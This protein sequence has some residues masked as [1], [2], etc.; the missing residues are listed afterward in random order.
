MRKRDVEI[1]T[2]ILQKRNREGLFEQLI[3]KYQVTERTLRNDIHSINDYLRSLDMPPILIRSDGT[4]EFDGTVDEQLILTR[5]SSIDS[6]TYRMQ[7]NER[8]DIIL[9]LLITRRDY[10]TMEELAE[11]LYVSRSSV[12]KDVNRLKSSCEERG[13]KIQSVLG[14]GITVEAEETVCRRELFRIVTD[15]ITLETQ[16][17]GSFQN[18]LLRELQFEISLNQV[19]KLVRRNER[20]RHLHF[21]DEGYVCFTC[22]L[23]VTL[24]RIEKGYF[25]DE[26]ERQSVSSVE[27][28]AVEIFRDAAQEL[29]LPVTPAECV[30]MQ[31]ETQKWELLLENRFN[32]DYLL[33]ENCV[34]EFIHSISRGLQINYFE[35]KVL[36]D[37]VLYLTEEAG[38]RGTEEAGENSML[39]Q[40]M[41][42]YPKEYRVVRESARVLEESQSI[43][44]SE[45]DLANLIMHVTAAG[46]RLTHF[47]NVLRILI[48]CPGNMATGQFLQ[49]QVHR[50][51]SYKIKAVCSV[52]ELYDEGQ[53]EDVDMVI[54]TVPIWNVPCPHVVVSPLLKLEDIQHIQ[55]TAFQIL[56]RNGFRQQSSNAWNVMDRISQ[57][58]LQEKN[59]AVKEAMISELEAI[60][61][62]FSTMRAKR[63]SK[64]REL[65]QPDTVEIAQRCDSWRTAVRRAGRMLVRKGKITNE[66]IDSCIR[67]CEKNGP[68][69]VLSNGLAIAH[70][71]PENGLLEPGVSLLYIKEGVSFEHEAYGSVRL[72][73][74]ICLKETNNELLKLLLDCAGDRKLSEL[75]EKQTDSRKVYEIL[76]DYEI[77]SESR[78]RNHDE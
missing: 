64:L 32:K 14:R 43:T 16:R 23:F 35:D 12:I 2:A 37:C 40:I 78:R 75:L 28:I 66:Y 74:F 9:L 48:V 68:Y 11:A 55:E 62:K 15:N 29:G 10:V 41:E 18:I 36:F 47:R 67:S 19:E 46:E 56:S 52:R 33:L 58:L 8:E 1:L 45:R 44:L 39:D 54:S 59:S 65:M 7:M 61:R 31:A 13:L 73:F 30:Q 49:A 71:H 17:S 22:Y 76:S 42:T 69:F 50:H 77:Q 20:K 63:I 26:G 6:Y 53:L 34:A 51:F 57:M 5:L 60:E 72:L 25:L 70:T 3:R 21:S 38:R 24:N 4:L 27:N